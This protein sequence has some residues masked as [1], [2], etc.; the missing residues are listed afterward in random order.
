MDDVLEWIDRRLHILEAQRQVLIEVRDEIRA[1]VGKER[2][3][4]WAQVG[5]RGDE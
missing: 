5:H 1:E 3:D 2:P 4:G